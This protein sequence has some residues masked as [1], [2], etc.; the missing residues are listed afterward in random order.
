M[1]WFKSKEQK[2]KEELEAAQKE[3]QLAEKHEAQLKYR[4]QLNKKWSNHLSQ[5]II[6][7]ESLESY[8]RR[9]G[10]AVEV[11]DTRLDDKGVVLNVWEGCLNQQQDY[12]SDFLLEHLIKSG[13]EAVVEAN[14]FMSS[15]TIVQQG[16]GATEINSYIYGLPVAR[17]KSQGPPYR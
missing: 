7:P 4:A 13:I 17:K 11:I 9:M 14:Y 10:Y 15:K 5:V 12:I 1:A 16:W 6:T 2:Q 3:R 8:Q